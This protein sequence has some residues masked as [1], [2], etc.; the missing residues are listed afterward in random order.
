MD[1]HASLAAK[2]KAA[3][4]GRLAAR[5]PAGSSSSWLSDGS[6][7]DDHKGLGWLVL[8]PIAC[9][10][11]PL[12]VAAVAAGGGAAWGGL[13]AGLVVIAVAAAFIV[14]RRRR[15]AACCA[16]GVPARATADGA[17]RPIRMM[18]EEP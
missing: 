1:H 10:G 5:A 14:V 16:P 8:L 6:A 11:G 4:P 13:G 2:P 12:I 18:P 3:D 7:R 17:D 15:A 9:C